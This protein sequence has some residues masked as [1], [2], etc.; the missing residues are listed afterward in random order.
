MAV[1]MLDP[2]P[3]DNV[4]DPAC[5][6]GGFLNQTARWASNKKGKGVKGDDR[7]E[8]FLRMNIY[9]IEKD[10]DLVEIAR[11][12]SLVTGRSP[13]NVLHM[14]TLELFRGD[15]DELL[16]TFDIVLTN[17]P[18]GSKIKVTDEDLLRRFDLGHRWVL[19]EETGRWERTKRV[20]ER[21]PQILFIEICMALLKEGGRCAI[22]LPDG[23]FGNP[24]D[25]WVRQFILERA[26]VLAVV[27]CP[28]DTF[29]PATHTKTSVLFFQKRQRP[30]DEYQLFMSIVD[31]C[32][33]D[34][35]GGVISDDEGV[36][37][38]EFSEVPGRYKAFMTGDPKRRKVDRLGFVVRRRSLVENILV[39][40]HY[41]PDLKR[42]ISNLERSGKF[43]LLSIDD[44]EERGVLEI[45]NA[46]ATA[47]KL[48]YGTGEVPFIRTSDIGNGEVLYPTTHSVSRRVYE[49]YSGKQDLRPG[50]ILIIKDGT[51]KVG[52]SIILLEQD[53]EALVQ[54]H[55]K[56]IRVKR[57]DLL[58]A[59]LLYHLLQQPIVMKQIAL[60]TFVQATLS[61]IGKRFGKVVLPIPREKKERRKVSKEVEDRLRARRRLL[62]ELR[63][64]K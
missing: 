64:I 60:N 7:F 20:Q 63:E 23:L 18:F 30:R 4:I 13:D 48:Q 42:E 56:V 45:R 43:D 17:P 15:P 46:P 26:E 29:M 24:T 61:T 27:D 19:D 59:F 34:S 21:E 28:H 41:D 39:P 16:G 55:F 53:V 54:S 8:R 51:Y 35:R 10:A 50:D 6:S 49:R 25:G 14:D 5:G 40:G 57:N 47:S 22:V 37:D 38:E 58:D 3:M 11:G 12:I 44:L 9:G 36:V 2:G 62:T 31:R 33:H 32:G 52:R 1:A